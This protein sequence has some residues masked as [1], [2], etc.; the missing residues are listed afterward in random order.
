MKLE[1]ALPNA[2]AGPSDCPVERTLKLLSGKWRLLVLFHLGSGPVRWGAL[3][4]DLAPITARVLTATLRALEH[5]GL[6]WRRS[7][8]SIPPVVTYGLT[9][10]GR[11]LAPT[12]DAMAQWG[13]KHMPHAGR[14]ETAD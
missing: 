6:I 2:D 4:R 8:G 11:A 10:S 5:D 3:R 7:E 1:T 14:K 13:L 9:D 12:F